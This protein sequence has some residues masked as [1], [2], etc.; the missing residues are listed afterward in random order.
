MIFL[1]K[2]RIVEIQSCRNIYVLLLLGVTAKT[3]SVCLLEQKSGWIQNELVHDGSVK[4][5][6][7]FFYPH[8]AAHTKRPDV[9]TGGRH[10]RQ[11]NASGVG[12]VVG[13]LILIQCLL[14][15][16]REGANGA[17]L[18][19]LTLDQSHHTFSQGTPDF[20]FFT[21]S[22]PFLFLPLC[23]AFVLSFIFILLKA[24]EREK[25]KQG[26]QR[27]SSQQSTEGAGWGLGG[28][29]GGYR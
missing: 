21:F 27:L 11:Q 15:L 29:A 28:A 18:T 19:R 13:W 12:G 1:V 9:Q 25:K 8:T 24:K 23:V 6:Y 20:F 14:Y 16:K 10:A 3:L 17:F 7:T 5:P 2:N 26:R 22:P 4:H